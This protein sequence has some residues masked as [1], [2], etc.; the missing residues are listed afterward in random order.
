[1]TY[2][3]LELVLIACLGF[4]AVGVAL[5]VRRVRELRQREQEREFDLWDWR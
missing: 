3:P 5:I 4:I 1:M 2:I